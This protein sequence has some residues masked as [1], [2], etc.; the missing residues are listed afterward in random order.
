MTLLAIHNWNRGQCVDCLNIFQQ[1][2]PSEKPLALSK[3]ETSFHDASHERMLPAQVGN[4]KK[5]Q[6]KPKQNNPY[7]LSPE[8]HRS[9]HLLYSMNILKLPSHTTVSLS[10]L[11]HAHI[12]RF[13]SPLSPALTESK[14]NWMRGVK[15]NSKTALL[16]C[17]STR[18]T[19]PPELS[20]P[21]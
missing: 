16:Y 3:N 19:D 2:S 4:S 7:T 17:C 11:I 13:F 12:R 1:L 8:W 15:T 14:Q 9:N 20:Q 5:N 18:L 10:V 6:P 21:T